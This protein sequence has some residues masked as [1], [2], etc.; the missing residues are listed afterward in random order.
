MAGLESRVDQGAGI[1]S[2]SEAESRTGI[3]SESEP[4]SGL[5]PEST[6][7]EMYRAGRG[8]RH[9]VVSDYEGGEQAVAAGAQAPARQRLRLASTGTHDSLSRGF[10]LRRGYH[11]T[12]GTHDRLS[13]GHR[14]SQKLDLRGENA[15]SCSAN[16]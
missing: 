2:E 1:E 14:L 4:E 15:R 6:N 13:R 5:E 10:D 7:N 9:K 11:E 16:D 8:I 3:G 12:P